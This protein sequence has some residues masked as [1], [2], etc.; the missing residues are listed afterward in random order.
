MGRGQAEVPSPA[1][2]VTVAL[3]SPWWCPTGSQR[4]GE[5]EPPALPS[6]HLVTRV[7]CGLSEAPVQLPPAE[8]PQTPASTA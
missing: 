6:P 7:C 4:Q 8:K 1:P 5:A 2:L 3:T